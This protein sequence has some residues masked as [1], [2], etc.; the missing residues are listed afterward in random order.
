[1]AKKKTHY[2]FVSELAIKNSNVEVIGKYNGHKEPIQSCCRLCGY[3]W[4]PNA[5]NLLNGQGCPICGRKRAS[6]RITKTHE[7]FVKDIK[8]RNPTVIVLGQYKNVNSEILCQCKI[9]N[10]LW[11][12]KPN[13][14]MKGISCPKC[15]HTGTS[16]EE[17][18]IYRAL[19]IV[20]GEEKVFSRDRKAIGK[21]LDIYIPS[22]SLAIEPG[23]WFWHKDKVKK[24]KE[25][26]QICKSKGIDLIVIYDTCNKKCSIKDNNFWIFDENLSLET[27]RGK[28][29][30]IVE[31]ILSVY[32]FP[33]K[34][35]PNE[36]L[37]L[38][39][40]AIFNSRR[41]TTDDFIA[42]LSKINTKV[43][44][45]GE[46]KGNKSP[47]KCRCKICNY[48][49]RATPNALLRGT[50][51]KKCEYKKNGQNRIKSH[52]DFLKELSEINKDIEVIGIYKS[53]QEH[54]ECKCKN[55]GRLWNPR[56]SDLLQGKG[57]SICRKKNGGRKLAK[58]HEQFI[59][60]ISVANPTIKILGKY[61]NRKTPIECTCTICGYTW[62]PTP[63]NILHGHGCPHCE[64]KEHYTFDS[65]K[66]KLALL[67]PNIE[68]LGEYVNNRTNIL[69]IC[70]KCTYQWS[71]TPGSLLSGQGCPLCA[72]KLIYDKDSFRLK[73]SIV[74][75]SIELL[76]NYESRDDRIKCKCKIC[77]YEW[78]PVAKSLLIGRGCPKKRKH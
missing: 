2:R 42:E 16:F 36:V 49:W 55:C 52:Q 72:G 74:N 12:A 34:F 37:E 40:Y 30:E 65:F 71:P 45:L 21:E 62:M 58:T 73:M 3:N 77:G 4:N 54:I 20:L 31:K 32:Y 69:C 51:C 33:H 68:L 59:E 35:L 6:I 63:N 25:K 23:S 78:N 57:C 14:L 44:V 39:N 64:G 17:Q 53:A 7:Q 47:I 11:S 46:Y 56:P 1:M 60:E 19:Q 61:I 22:L 26:I 38:T 8:K 66:N 75:L 29:V 67:N 5:G 50:S 13:S 15:C 10:N 18:F 28:L 76:G 27:N 48:E 41:K 9:C 24:D 43:E 70:K